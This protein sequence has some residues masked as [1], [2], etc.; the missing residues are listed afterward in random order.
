MLHQIL[1]IPAHC[2]VQ[3]QWC[4]W[5]TILIMYPHHYPAML[6]LLLLLRCLLFIRTFPNWHSKLLLCL[7]GWASPGAQV[8]Y[9]SEIPRLVNC[10]VQMWLG[11]YPNNNI[12]YHR[13]YSKTKAWIKNIVLCSNF[14][15]FQGE[16]YLYLEIKKWTLGAPILI[17]CKHFRADFVWLW[18]V[19]CHVRALPRPWCYLNVWLID[20]FYHAMCPSLALPCHAVT[21]SVPRPRP[22]RELFTVIRNLL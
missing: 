21:A 4:A 18:K 6:C 1:I 16:H 11:I 8:G 17:L 20:I 13:M 15:H 14:P 3:E 2:T 7:T 12:E 5:K 22:C 9:V 10:I 19:P